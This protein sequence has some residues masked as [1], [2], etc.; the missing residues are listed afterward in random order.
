MNREAPSLALLM[1]PD[2]G[3]VHRCAFRSR[4]LRSKRT[5]QYAKKRYAPASVR[6]RQGYNANYL[7]RGASSSAGPDVYTDDDGY[8]RFHAVP[9]ESGDTSSGLPWAARTVPAKLTRTPST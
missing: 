9:A 6:A 5:G 2:C 1:D 7:P 3:A 8:A 4:R